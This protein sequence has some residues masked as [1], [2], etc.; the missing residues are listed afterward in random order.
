MKKTTLIFIMGLLISPI[1]FGKCYL[2]ISGK[3]EQVINSCNVDVIHKA[4][5]GYNTAGL[6]KFKNSSQIEFI[7]INSSEATKPNPY[8][9]GDKGSPKAQTFIESY[10]LNGNVITKEVPPRSGCFIESTIEEDGEYRKEFFK[11]ATSK[12][13]QNIVNANKLDSELLKSGRKKG[14]RIINE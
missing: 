6:W 14:D 3:E 8:V 11:S 13:S 5:I 1:A 10:K 2:S 12:C 7:M 4:L 9:V